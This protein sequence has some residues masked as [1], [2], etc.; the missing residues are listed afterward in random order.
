[1]DDKNYEYD[2]ETYVHTDKETG[3]KYRWNQG[4]NEWELIDAGTGSS[5]VQDKYAETLKSPSSS[6][7][8]STSD[9]AEAT[10]STEKDSNAAE[11]VPTGTYTYDGDTAIYTDPT[12]GTPYEWDKE[13]NAWIP[14]VI[15]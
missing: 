8:K 11:S 7:E 14:R 4:K 3:V 15:M 13:K 1:M 2:G 10:C 5:S 9:K 6:N 12:D